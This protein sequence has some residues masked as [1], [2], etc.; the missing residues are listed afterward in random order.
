MRAAAALLGLCLAGCA[1]M[2]ADDCARA[3][4]R[5]LGE[6]DALDGH[7]AA[8]LGKRAKACR[9]HQIGADQ[10]AYEAGHALGQRAYCS[11]PRGEGDAAA[12]LRPA[13]LCL[14]PLQ[15]AYERGFSRGLQTF[16]SPRNAYEHGRA[17]DGDPGTCPE[18]SRRGFETGWRLGREVYEL[19]QRRQ[20]LLSDAAALRR[21]AAD[22]KLR[23]EERQQASR[24]ASE[25]E[26]E[27]QR[28]RSRQ[29]EAE[30]DA[31]S[32]PR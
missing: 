17:G 22:D 23:P 30:M 13:E 10:A 24:H 31:L 2:D 29:R 12:G 9:K 20:R 32:L 19:E 26:A 21:R 1:V 28:V 5:E 11:E 14:A 25:L 18:L 6:R 27:A 3:N 4:W 15:P 16:C 7:T 8:R